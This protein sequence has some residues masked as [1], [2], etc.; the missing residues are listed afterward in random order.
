M[1][2]P[3]PKAGNDLAIR[4]TILGIVKAKDRTGRSNTVHSSDFRNAI[5]DLG[6]SM[7]SPIIEN[8]LIYCK[9]DGSGNLDYSELERELTRERR[10]YNSTYKQEQPNVSSSQGVVSKPWRGDKVHTARVE[11][12]KQLLAITE[13][14][15]EINQIYNLLSHHEMN[16]SEAMQSL[17]ELQIYPTKE[18]LRI[19]QDMMINPIPYAD[20]IRSLTRYSSQKGGSSVYPSLL[21]SPGREGEREG[22]GIRNDELP[23]GGFRVRTELSGETIGSQRKRSTGVNTAFHESAGFFEEQKPRSYRKMVSSSDNPSVNDK[24]IFKNKEIKNI[25]FFD[26]DNNGTVPL[27]S[28]NQEDMVTGST[29]KKNLRNEHG[30]GTTA[31]YNIEQRLQREQVSAALRK[32]DNGVITMDDFQDMLFSL[33]IDIPEDFMSEIRRGVV[34]GRLDVRKYM[35]MLDANIFKSSVIDMVVNDN[36]A[37]LA[38]KKFRENILKKGFEAFNNLSLIFKEID[39]NNDG[40][41]TFSEFKNGCKQMSILFNLNDVELRSLFHSFDK[42][43][44][45]ELQYEEFLIGIR[46]ELSSI[47]KQIVRKAFKKLDRHCTGNVSLDVVGENFNALNHPQVM[48]GEKSAKQVITDFLRWFSSDEV[49]LGSSVFVLFFSPLLSPF[50]LEF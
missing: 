24:V 9:L 22:E 8:I 49:R 25:L 14:S 6:F 44:D 38:A 41:L 7:G 50:L 26:G 46:G 40:K 29:G 39:E 48:T 36:I 45:G 11:S 1:N 5:M 35:K 4:E 21:T 27:L 19:V 43:G 18:F 20:F 15:S 34:S 2:S 30:N 12:E 42:N 3:S 37:S 32:L 23:A 28:H 10:I 13:Y 31:T 17:E 33:G 16:P 47:R